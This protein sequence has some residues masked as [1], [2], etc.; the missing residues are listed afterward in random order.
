MDL[1]AQ[2]TGLRDPRE[3]SHNY[4]WVGHPKYGSTKLIFVVLIVRIQTYGSVQ[5]GT[6]L[7]FGILNHLSVTNT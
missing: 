7:N 1:E 6:F 4:R 5:G 2:R 3:V